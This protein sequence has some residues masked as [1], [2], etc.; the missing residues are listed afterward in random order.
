MK[1]ARKDKSKFSEKSIGKELVAR[2]KRFTDK[3]SDS[4]KGPAF[5]CKTVRLNLELIPYDSKHV[6]ETRILLNVSQPIFA[7]FL[8]VSVSAIRDWEQ[9]LKTPNGPVCRL[10]DEIRNNPGYW[11]SRL[12]TMIVPVETA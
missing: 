5:N 3:M 6:K 4:E 9:G 1:G 10:M 11:R 8:G 7:Q 12:S 2:L